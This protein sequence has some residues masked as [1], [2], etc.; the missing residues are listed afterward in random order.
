MCLARAFL[1]F[2]IR[3]SAH[4]RDSYSL[5]CSLAGF[6]RE[7]NLWPAQCMELKG[8]AV[9]VMEKRLWDRPQSKCVTQ[10]LGEFISRSFSAQSGQFANTLAGKR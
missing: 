6:L 2:L 3:T 5:K 10:I 7:K 8:R 1:I 9:Y 4:L